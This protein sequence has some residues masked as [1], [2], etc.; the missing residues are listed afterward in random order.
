[1]Q[2]DAPDVPDISAVIYPRDARLHPRNGLPDWTHIRLFIKFKQ[3]AENDP[4]N[5]TNGHLR[6]WPR[7]RQDVHEQLLAYAANTFQYQHRTALF[8]LLI[9]G[10]EFRAMYWD[11]SGLV[12]TDATNY[13]NDPGSLVRF[14]WAFANLQEEHQGI[15]RTATLLPEDSVHFKLMDVCAHANPALD[16]PFS[17][18]ADVSRWF[19]ESQSEEANKGSAPGSR[20]DS[21]EQSPQPV[22][23]YVRDGFRDSL[24]LGWPRYRLLVGKSKREF[25]VARPAFQ[26][27]SMFGR[28]T[29]GYIALDVQNHR[30][31]WLKD[32]WRPFYEGVEPEGHYLETMAS[33]PDIELSIPTVVAHGDVL[34][35]TTYAVEYPKD[36]QMRP[37]T[38]PAESASGAAMPSK[39]R[40]REDGTTERPEDSATPQPFIHY[41][42]VVEEVCL[43]MGNFKNGRQ[44]V[45]LIWKCIVSEYHC[46]A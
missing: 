28:G 10:D 2:N 6:A 16:A 25:L 42:I 21:T 32:S 39:K 12:V 19:S 3:G 30:F 41:R 29:R 7:S 45:R 11:R 38:S 8:S 33:K 4:F 9:N 44:L 15:D 37:S 23:Q 14:L 18:G 26:S 34:Q 31:V 24:I 36:E 35:Q 5:D 27:T 40:A 22:F 13:A 1:M 17:E 43:K 46:P 20:Q